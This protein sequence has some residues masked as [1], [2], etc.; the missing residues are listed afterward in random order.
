MPRATCTIPGTAQH[1]MLTESIGSA[2]AG[3]AAHE[4]AHSAGQSSHSPSSTKHVL[5]LA[6][7]SP[8]FGCL[9]CCCR[10]VLQTLPLHVL[11]NASLEHR[12]VSCGPQ[13]R[14]SI[15]S[16]WVLHRRL[17]LI[18]DCTSTHEQYDRHRQASSLGRPSRE[19]RTSHAAHLA[20]CL[21]VI[22]SIVATSAPS[23]PI[24]LYAMAQAF[25]S[26]LMASAMGTA[27]SL[28]CDA[29]ST[30]SNSYVQRPEPTNSTIQCS[31]RVSRHTTRVSQASSL[32]CNMTLT[33]MHHE[34]HGPAK[35]PNHPHMH[36]NGCCVAQDSGTWHRIKSASQPPSQQC[37]T[38]SSPETVSGPLLPFQEPNQPRLRRSLDLLQD[39]KVDEPL[40]FPC[41]HQSLGQA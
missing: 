7:N 8:P 33:N 4:T 41:M 20:G 35:T 22:M 18:I 29:Q 6:H 13:H 1:S 12:R 24:S 38:M 36:G 26:T 37:S 14:S 21:P 19:A 2:R 30:Q 25:S 32:P 34:N 27:S 10:L 17:L 9:R 31:C 28:P 3:L 40:R 39:S 5:R 23:F 16:V 15:V 11:C